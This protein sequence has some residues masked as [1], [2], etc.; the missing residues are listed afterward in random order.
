MRAL[1][2]ITLLLVGLTASTATSAHAKKPTPGE[3]APTV[4]KTAA[5]AKAIALAKVPGTIKAIELEKEHGTWIYSVEI[6]P[7]NDKNPK[8]I[9]EISV[10]ATSGAIINIEDEFEDNND[11][12]ND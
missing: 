10:D 8:H 2:A 5:E 3:K 9:K 6:K 12:D 7:T 4:K 1:P 11:K